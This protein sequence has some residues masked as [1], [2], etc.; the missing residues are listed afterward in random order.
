MAR[1]ASRAV[2]I[3]ALLTATLMLG[4]CALPRGGPYVSE[5]EAGAGTALPFDVVEVTPQVVAKARFD[6]RLGFDAAFQETSVENTTL[7]NRGDVLSI[8]VWENSDTGLLNESGIG[9]T[10]LPSVKVDERGNV[11]VPYVG[12]VRAAGRSL[13]QLR[14]SIR[15]QLAERTLNPQVDVFP[16]VSEGRLVSV[17]GMV[18]TPGIYP[19][20][21]GTRRVLPMLAQ[22]G[23]IKADPEVVKVRVRRGVATGEIWLQ[24]LY[25]EPQ[26]NVA[27]K[28][29]DAVIAERDR[30]IFTALGAVGRP[31]TVPFPVRELS[32]TR[33][34]G[35][36]AGLI[37][38]TADPTG[39]FLFRAEPEAVAR[40]VLEDRTVQGE[41]RIVYV[42][43]LTKPGGMFLAREFIMRDDDTL[44]VTT[45]PFV[46]FQK[47]LQSIAPVLGLAG[48]TRSLSGL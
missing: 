5:I 21:T 12:R 43:D 6:E 29:G 34:L 8:T 31:A 3:G 39:I 9:A 11:H 14:S 45:A 41:R 27:L 24:D 44:Y 46:Q 16:E 25:D 23:G 4:A 33:A 2:R 28:P 37:D 26:M 10:V 1:T 19:I 35:Q 22:A 17:Q 7:V 18:N 42:I 32:V 15:Q 30:R 20:R 47:V 13:S 38:A 48:T 36:V 40:E